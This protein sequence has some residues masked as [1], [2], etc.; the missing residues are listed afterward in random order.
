L[1]RLR[2]SRKKCTGELGRLAL[3]RWAG[4]SAGQLCRHVKCW[5]RSQRATRLQRGKGRRDWNRGGGFGT[6]SR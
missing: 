6:L 2:L 4:W 3:A 1:I 5:N